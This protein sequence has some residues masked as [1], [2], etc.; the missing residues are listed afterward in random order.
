[1]IR[2]TEHC[3][4]HGTKLFYLEAAGLSN[5]CQETSFGMKFPV[6]SYRDGGLRGD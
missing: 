2:A 5:R 4:R 6:V 3:Y 1:M